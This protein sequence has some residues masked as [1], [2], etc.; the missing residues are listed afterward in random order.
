MIT[1]TDSS[2]PFEFIGISKTCSDKYQQDTL[3][4]RF[5]SSKSSH[6][7]EVHVERYVEHLSCI[8]FFD[9]SSSH[10]FGRFSQ[11]SETF[12]P[13]TIFRTVANI[14]LDALKRD[15]L[16]SFCFIG[17]ADDRDAPDGVQTRRYRVYKAYIRR[18]GL[19]EQF[20]S[21]FFDQHSFAALIN[22]KAVSD[23][24]AYMQSILDFI[25]D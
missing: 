2:Y 11:L 20:E 9:T 6:E 5:R 18:L 14:A 22:R 19:E 4:Y 8:K 15:P 13:R 21:A 7:Y 25:T 24:D 16:S 3:I 12:E 10:G 17:A 23:M 1:L